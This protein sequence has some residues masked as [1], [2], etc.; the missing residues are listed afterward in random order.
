MLGNDRMETA[1][2]EV[3]SIRH[4]NNMEKSTWRIHQ[5]YADFESRI[6]VEIS[7]WI[8]LSKPMKSRRTSHVE[9][10]QQIDEESA[11]MCALGCRPLYLGDQNFLNFRCL[12]W[13][14]QSHFDVSGNLLIVSTL[15]P[16]FPLFLF[17][18]F[19]T[20]KNEG[21]MALQTLTVSL[22]LGQ[23]LAG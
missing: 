15:K 19:A 3:T 16:F 6:H 22:A 4:R 17:F 2:T 10:Q 1:S 12:E 21:G 13:L 7:T 9:F 8:R 14:K 18:L 23:Y 11:K 5:Y 20:Q